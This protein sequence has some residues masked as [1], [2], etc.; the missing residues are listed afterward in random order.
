M[1]NEEPAD[2]V[3]TAQR[4]E[5]S[6]FGRFTRVR[7]P[8]CARPA[9]LTRLRWARMKKIVVIATGC[10]A[11]LTGAAIVAI[12]PMLPNVLSLYR[13]DISFAVATEK[14]E[15]FITIDDAP[16]AST[17]EILAVLRKHEVP[18]TFF[19]ISSRVTD[20]S[21]LEEIVRAR[22]SLGNHLQST[23]AC[24]T[25]SLSEFRNSLDA[26]SAMLARFGGGDFFRPASDF[27]TREQIAYARTRGYE[28]L[29]GT[30][31]PMDHWITDPR[32]ITRLARWLSTPG[33]I[34][35]LHDGTI[36]GRTTAA[37]L[38]RLIPELRAAG[39]S[40][41]RLEKPNKGPEPISGLSPAMAHH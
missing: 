11:V 17:T 27:G 40:F 24:S 28:P 4:G 3:D 31:F 26:C 18:A 39:Y 21:Q 5:P 41:G 35:I 16:S 25:L 10:F 7:N 33:G 34:V 30:V 13:S 15:V 6:V 20:D 8:I 37:V 22:H 9:W 23:K 29:V 12:P 38:D 19:I 36:R 14:K 1:R 32:S 2:Q